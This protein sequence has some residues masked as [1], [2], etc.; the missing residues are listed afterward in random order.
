MKRWWI[1]VQADV[2]LEVEAE[3]E[4]A[5]EAEAERQLRSNEAELSP[6][7]DWRWARITAVRAEPS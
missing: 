4:A 7:T 2:I 6:R 5:A 3:S 1:E